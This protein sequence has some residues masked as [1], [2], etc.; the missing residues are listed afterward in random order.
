MIID[1]VGPLP[2]SSVTDVCTLNFGFLFNPKRVFLSID[3][4]RSLTHPTRLSVVSLQVFDILEGTLVRL[5]RVSLRWSV[6]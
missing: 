5:G 4:V 1:F 2:E 6:Y 3:V